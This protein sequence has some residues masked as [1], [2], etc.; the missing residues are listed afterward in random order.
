MADSFTTSY[1]SVLK[2][3][4]I[5][6]TSR[7][8]SSERQL[9]KAE[10]RLGTKLPKA[11]RSYYALFG[12]HKLNRTHNRLLAPED[13]FVAK[14]R[15]VFMEENQ[16]VVYWGVPCRSA[17]LDPPVF[18]TTDPED[19]PWCRECAHCS[20]FLA[21]MFCWQ[22]VQSPYGHVGFSHPT[23]REAVRKVAKRWTFIGRMRELTAYAANGQPVCVLAE[24]KS[25]TVQV[26]ASSEKGLVD[27]AARY[28]VDIHP[29]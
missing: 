2:L 28:G 12:K 17:A 1:R 25:A 10:H 6:P 3:L 7:D 16:N 5:K 21:V 19:G 4:D 14:G 20:K 8:A 11:L 23:D 15:L 9:D 27:F 24:G 26:S 18:Q 29:V 22:S 13:L